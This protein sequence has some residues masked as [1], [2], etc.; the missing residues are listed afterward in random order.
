ML[1]DAFRAPQDVLS[2]SP[3]PPCRQRFLLLETKNMAVYE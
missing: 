3:A 1:K 2:I